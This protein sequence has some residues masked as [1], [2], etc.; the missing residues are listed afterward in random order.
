M[1]TYTIIATNNAGSTESLGTSGRTLE[2][3]PTGVTP[4]IFNSKQARSLRISWIAPTLPNGIINLYQVFI[5]SV[6]G[7]ELGEVVN[8]FS[9]LAFSAFISGYYLHLFD[10]AYDQEFDALT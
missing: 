1:F 10:L 3:I 6:S 9:G 7:V 2:S 8:V 5:T 4:I